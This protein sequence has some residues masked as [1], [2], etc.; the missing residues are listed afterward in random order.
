MQLEWSLPQRRCY[1]KSGITN[2]F[3]MCFLFKLV[4]SWM[5]IFGKMC[6]FLKLDRPQA[7]QRKPFKVNLKKMLQI[8]FVYIIFIHGKCVFKQHSAWEKKPQHIAEI[9]IKNKW[10]NQRMEIEKKKQFRCSFLIIYN[11]PFNV[12][13]EYTWLGLFIFVSRGNV[14][15]EWTAWN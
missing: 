1:R 6:L 13:I 12:I 9:L 8:N 10:F 3:F 5:E 7:E 4:N 14:N 15:S 11:H 2:S